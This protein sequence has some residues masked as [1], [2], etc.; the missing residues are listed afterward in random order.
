MVAGL[1]LGGGIGYLTR[2][3]GL[4][5]DNLVSVDVDSLGELRPA[6]DELRPLKGT[7][8]TIDDALARAVADLQ[9]AGRT[10]AVSSNVPLSNWKVASAFLPPSLT[11]E[12]FQ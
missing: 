5:L 3:H 8:G 12:V 4:S 6:F 2:G 7:V 10:V 11:E 9:A 1:T